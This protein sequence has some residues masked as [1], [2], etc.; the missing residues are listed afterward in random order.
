MATFKDNFSKQS[1]IYV[2]YRPH[3]PPAL[4]EYLSSLTKNHELVWD[5]GTGNGQAATGLA[6]FY[7]SII[8]TDPSEQ[9]IKNSIPH[10]KVNYRIEKAEDNSVPSNSVDLLTI[11]NALHWLDFDPFFEQARRVL[12]KDGIIAAWAYRLPVI[13][14]EVDE[15]VH[16]F[17]YGILDSYWLPE[18]RLVEKEYT[19]I[20]FPFKSIDVPDFHCEKHMDLDGLI[21]YL[22]TWSALQ[23][24]ISQNNFNPTDAL[25]EE[26]QTVWKDSA[27]KKKHT[28]KLTLKVG[29]PAE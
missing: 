21:G 23:R 10:H 7:D 16:K 1:D 20:P 26:L 28:W 6:E 19:T 2:K 11:A 25:R 8:A 4:Y 17:H 15:I 27:E 12:K 18:N 5:C 9:Q 24:F 22:N 14:P 29:R 3:Y 13:S